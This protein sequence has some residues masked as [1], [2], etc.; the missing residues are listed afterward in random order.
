MVDQIS[1]EFQP[2]LVLCWSCTLQEQR[3]QKGILL[4]GIMTLLFFIL[5]CLTRSTFIVSWYLQRVQHTHCKTYY[6]GSSKPRLH[7]RMR[8]VTLFDKRVEPPRL[9]A[10]VERRAQRVEISVIGC[11]SIESPRFRTLQRCV[12]FFFA[13]NQ[14]GG[15]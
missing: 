7:E 3:N 5:S 13:M 1:L 4:S 8:N 2:S 6:A 14:G 9:L 11:K 12:V 10:G 15:G